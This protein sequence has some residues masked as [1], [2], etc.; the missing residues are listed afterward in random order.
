M[1]NINPNTLTD[2]QDDADGA[3]SNSPQDTALADV[4][5]T[6]SWV[7]T[8]RRVISELRG[9]SVALGWL[10]YLGLNSAPSPAAPTYISTTSFSLPNDWTS[11][12]TVGRRVKATVTTSTVYGTIT[13]ASYV[14]P[15]TTITL[16]MDAGQTLDAGLTE[17]MFGTQDPAHPMTL[18]TV[19]D[20]GSTHF[21]VPLNQGGTGN[22]TGQPSGTASG[23]LSG[24]Y[25]SPTV[26]KIRGRDVNAVVAPANGDAFRW[27][28]GTSEWIPD[29]I[30]GS[31]VCAG[32]SAAEVRSTITDK[33]LLS[34]LAMPGWVD[35]PVSDTTLGTST[36]T[37]QVAKVAQAMGGNATVN[38]INVSFAKAFPTAVLAV[39]P[40]MVYPT[41]ARVFVSWTES[42]DLDKAVLKAY[43]QSGAQTVTFYVLAIGY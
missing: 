21:V 18:P 3:D 39:Y 12:A 42:A 9:V 4:N 37:I 27:N 34:L 23:D 26:A 31:E 7:A 40:V 25:P 30:V 16:A 8:L 5:S 14:A 6:T 20:D 35:I 15:I 38:P 22:I 2:W 11:I 17:V 33:V 28:A 36:L 24:T 32:L 19:E 43:N 1:A 41:D 10:R 29:A 13:D